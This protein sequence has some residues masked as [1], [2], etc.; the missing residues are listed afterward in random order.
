MSTET[1]TMTAGELWKLPDNGMRRELVRG[2]LREMTPAGFDHGRV[3]GKVFKQLASHVEDE[4]LGETTAAETGFFIGRDPDTVRA[5]DAAF[6][7]RERY[8]AHGPT[9]R[10]WPEA[11]D[12]AAEVVSP[13]DTFREVEEKALQWLDAGTKAVL[14]VDPARRTATVYRSRENV[15]VYE[16]DET[17]DLDDA[18]PGWRPSL[19]DLFA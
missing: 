19:A 9:K 5:P 6:V 18:V 2:E 4:A 15:H 11:P 3:A 14:V 10:F 17:I 16:E 12:F 1:A 8:E 7:S 13:E